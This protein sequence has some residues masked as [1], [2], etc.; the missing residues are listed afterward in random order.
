[1]SSM[2]NPLSMLSVKNFDLICKNEEFTKIM[3]LA[4]Q[5][6]VRKLKE[7]CKDISTFSK[8]IDTLPKT[9]KEKDKA[10]LSPINELSPELLSGM[11]VK[12]I[13]FLDIPEKALKIIKEK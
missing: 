7:Y 10:K 13:T 9:K 4:L 3:A 5:I 1:M 11:S 2:K 12:A 6:E 8:F